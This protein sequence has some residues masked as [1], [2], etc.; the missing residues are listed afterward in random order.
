MSTNYY[1]I[2]SDTD[3]VNKYFN[4]EYSTVEY[5]K[6]LMTI[7]DEHRCASD[8]MVYRVHIGKHSY[9][10]QPLFQAHK[11]AYDSIKGLRL[12]LRKHPEYIICDEYDCCM[13]F[14]DLKKDLMDSRKTKGDCDKYTLKKENGWSRLVKAPDDYGG[15]TFSSPVSHIEVAKAMHDMGDF[16]EI[17]LYTRDTEGYEFYDGEFC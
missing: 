7:F 15:L 12:F 8:S 9:G 3:S 6:C 11:N 16:S 13:T 2:T 4:G 14:N 17:D 10:W 5:D 1:L